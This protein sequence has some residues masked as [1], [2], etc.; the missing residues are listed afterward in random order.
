MKHL[1]LVVS[2]ILILHTTTSSP[3]AFQL[4]HF[5]QTG[6]TT[7]QPPFICEEFGQDSF[8]WP[9]FRFI[10]NDDGTLTE[11]LT[12][13]IWRKSEAC[14][15]SP[16]NASGCNAT[17]HAETVKICSSLP[18]P[19][20]HDN[21][22]QTIA[23]NC[24]HLVWVNDGKFLTLDSLTISPGRTNLGYIPAGI[25]SS[26][27]ELSINNEGSRPVSITGIF[28]K[29]LDPNQF[30]VRAGGSSPC[31][32]LTPTIP[33]GSKCT[34][35][36]TALPTSSGVKS[37][38][39]TL[40]TVTNSLD[41][42]YTVTAFNTVFG[43]IIDQSTGLQVTGATVTL[44][45]A[46]TTATGLDGSYH[47]ASLPAGNYSISISQT[48]FQPAARSDLVITPS[49]YA[50]ADI[51]LSTVGSLDM[52]STYLTWASPNLPYNS[53]VMVAGGTAPYT[54][55]NAYG[56]LPK[57]LF[58]DISTGTI[59]GIPIGGESY[60]FA[61]GVTD[62][63]AG[64]CEKEFLIELLP[65]L[66]IEISLPSGQLGQSYSSSISVTGGKPEYNI[67]VVG[68]T[69]PN[70]LTLDPDGLLSGTPLEVGTFSIRVRVTDSTGR[71]FETT[72]NLS[73]VIVEKLNGNTTILQEGNIR[74]DFSTSP[75]GANDALT[76]F[77]NLIWKFLIS[78]IDFYVVLFLQDQPVMPPEK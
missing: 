65:P 66:D 46:A 73:L 37:A 50:K 8:S 78:S 12:G 7:C 70:G 52:T 41:I 4:L 18:L 55:N 72:N 27:S 9:S 22:N 35:I 60:G 39:L 64:Y 45:N 13:F 2:I 44:S 30:T 15:N 38:A 28:F 51:L 69:L 1:I 33:T 62:S 29:G 43:T 6:L 3:H 36:V 58:L 11:E 67:A 31:S 61:I 75:S 26:Q 24:S 20:S 23:D 19:G 32:N 49:I 57:G 77:L 68:G 34:V 54:F 16:D 47:F 25:A 14:F 63:A 74:K 76:R 40:S 48:G 56:E 5:P 71:T 42:P 53:R 10:Y 17:D 59:S 21:D